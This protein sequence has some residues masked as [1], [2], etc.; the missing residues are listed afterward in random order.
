MTIVIEANSGNH[1]GDNIINFIFFYKIK[2]YIEEND[3]IINYYCHGQY[4]KN[5]LDFKTSNNIHIFEYE[6]KG[7]NLWQ[8]NVP[9]RT[10]IEDSLCEMFNIFLKH[11]NIPITVQDFEYQDPDLFIRLNQIDD[12]YTCI[13]TLVINSQPLSGQYS[14]CKTEWDNFIMELSKKHKV[15]TTEYV[16]DEILCINNFSVKNIAALSLKVKTIIAINTGPSVP[17]YNTDILNSVDNIYL[18]SEGGYTFKTRKIRHFETL[19]KLY[20]LL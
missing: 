5:L 4:H 1:L 18:L 9:V 7:Y 19:D 3:I 11:Y 20:F 16:N 6:N 8:A 15:A 17:L 2:E 10:Y 14:Y 12:K 13:D